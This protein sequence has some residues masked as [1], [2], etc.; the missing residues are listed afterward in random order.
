MLYRYLGWRNPRTVGQ[1]FYTWRMVED[2]YLTLL[3][4]LNK[5]PVHANICI[6][7]TRTGS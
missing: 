4:D 7:Y 3:Q 2:Y 5:E 6:A 1:F